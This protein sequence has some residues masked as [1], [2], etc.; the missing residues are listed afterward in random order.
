MIHFR[1][2][3]TLPFLMADVRH[4]VLLD[5]HGAQDGRWYGVITLNDGSG[6][7]SHRKYLSAITRA[8]VVKI[9]RAPHR[10]GPTDITHSVS[11]CRLYCLLLCI[12]G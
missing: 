7:G 6:N 9:L 5:S 8:E 1:R 12:L 2:V 3:R 4:L 10:V 11:Y